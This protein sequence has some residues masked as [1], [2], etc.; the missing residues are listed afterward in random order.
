MENNKNNETT[1]KQ[2]ARTTKAHA[3]ILDFQNMTVREEVV[4]IP[5]TRTIDGK[6]GAISAVAKT[7]GI[8]R[9]RITI[10]ELEQPERLTVEDTAIVNAAREILDEVPESVPEGFICV[11]VTKYAY[12]GAAFGF[13]ES[14]EPIANKVYFE[15]WEKVTKGSA[16]TLLEAE[17]RPMFNENGD[18]LYTVVYRQR[19]AM[20]RYAIV[21]L[22]TYHGMK[23]GF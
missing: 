23:Y 15:S 14:G 19:K 4:E 20:K 16:A 13:D 17:A 12:F 22:T 11:A 1:K 21:D 3:V 9:N 8:E 10:K 2:S 5:Y 6:N 7:L 18:G